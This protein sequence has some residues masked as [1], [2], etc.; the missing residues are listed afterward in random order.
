MKPGSASRNFLPP[1]ARARY[2]NAPE[3]LRR[4]GGE[5]SARYYSVRRR[6]VQDF[7][8]DPPDYLFIWVPKTA[9]TSLYSAFSQYISM[10]KLKTLRDVY[11]AGAEKARVRSLTFGHLSTDSLID[12]GLASRELFYS[13]DSL[14]VVRNPFD[15]AYS[16]HRYFRR[17]GRLHAAT[18]FENF[19]QRVYQKK[20]RSG[21]WHSLGLSQAAPMVDWLRPRNWPGPKEVLRFE[22]IEEEIQR[23]CSRRSLVISLPRENQG[24]SSAK[25]HVWTD[26]EIELIQEIYKE[27]FLEFGYE[28]ALPGG[29]RRT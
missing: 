29:F 14:G 25:T 3:T 8:I 28:L 17:I 12:L 20:P 26:A 24:T 11:G 21:P 2:Q 9:G 10:V 16:L 27:D 4:F 13:S 6:L 1:S 15:R 7:G 19:L 18:S 23:W 22:T 5:V